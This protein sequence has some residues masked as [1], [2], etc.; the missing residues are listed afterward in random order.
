[1]IRIEPVAARHRGDRPFLDARALRAAEHGLSRTV[2]QDLVVAG[3]QAGTDERAGRLQ[4]G[5]L[6]TTWPNSCYEPPR[7]ENTGY[8]ATLAQS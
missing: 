5:I 7:P 2:E 1:M 8:N 6:P 4:T 3:D